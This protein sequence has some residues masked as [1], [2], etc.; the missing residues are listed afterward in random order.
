MM[1]SQP[2]KVT[3]TARPHKAEAQQARARPHEADAQQAMV[4][5][6]ALLGRATTLVTLASGP[7]GAM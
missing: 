4:M 5:A 2:H 3:G 6:M 1:A 7:Q